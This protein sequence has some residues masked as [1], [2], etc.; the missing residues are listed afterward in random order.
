MKMRCNC[1][2][3]EVIP[4]SG[5]HDRIFKLNFQLKNNNK[6]INQWTRLKLYHMQNTSV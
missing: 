4:M 3:Q 5:M 6:L 2:S 1:L